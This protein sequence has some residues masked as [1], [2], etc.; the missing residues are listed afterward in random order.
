MQDGRAP[1]HAQLEQRVTSVEGVMDVTI[2]QDPCSVWID[3]AIVSPSSSCPRIL[4]QRARTDGAAART[5]EQVKRHRYGSRV[6]PFVI[7]TGGRPGPSARSNLNFDTVL[8]R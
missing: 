3:A 7:E 1:G 4:Q 5:E 8:Y 6:Q 2:A